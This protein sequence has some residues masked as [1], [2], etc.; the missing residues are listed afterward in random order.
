MPDILP[1]N[2]TQ[3]A[4]NILPGAP[5]PPSSSTVDPNQPPASK[6]PP[7]LLKHLSAESPG[8]F[9]AK[10]LQKCKDLLKMSR[11][12][13]QSFYPLWD[14]YDM[15]YR[16]ERYRDEA[17][18][19]ARERKEPEK[20]VIP[21]TYSQIDTF[22]AFLYQVYTQRPSFFEFSGTSAEDVQAAK[23]AEATMEYNLDR[24]KFRG[25]ILQ[26]FI[27]DIG[28]FGLGIMETSWTQEMVKVEQQVPMQMEQV[29]GMPQVQPPM[30][31]QI[32]D[33]VDYQGNKVINVSPYRF[34]PDPRLPI[35][36]FQEGEFCG[37]E[38]EYSEH[39]LQTMESNGEIAGLKYVP[40][41]TTEMMFDGLR[42]A[43]FSES[44][45]NQ[46]PECSLREPKFYIASIITLTLV[47]SM[48]KVDGVPLGSS[49]T[50]EKYRVWILNDA[51]IV[52]VEPMGY[53]HNQFTY[54]VAQFNND[55]IRFINFGLAELL[56][57]LQDVQNWFINSHITSVRKVISNRLIVDP[58]GIE[59][60]DL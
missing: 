24:N 59:M 48:W 37:H 19:K 3:D 23:L 36:R 47:P 53:L 54:S 40:R 32:V 13:M 50:P 39:T 25:L 12:E 18:T 42:R 35:T 16:T 43:S 8:D 57:Q 9:H 38:Y 15:A 5:L 21:M 1:V 33:K 46:T 4:S 2:S 11:D 27:L 34:F 60:Q 55:Q 6:M 22:C 44:I 56:E 20:M 29:P 31:T 45:Q 14:K 58:K 26:Q 49:T 30:T 51:R 10:L 7:M 41:V 52:K 28:R 17:D